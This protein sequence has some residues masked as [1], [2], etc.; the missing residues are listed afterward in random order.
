MSKISK[1][2]DGMHA[3]FS[4]D[5]GE[6]TGI[7]AGLFELHATLKATV[8]KGKRMHKTAEVYGDYLEQGREIAHLMWKFQYTMQVE[9]GIAA[10]R[11]HFIFEDFVLRRKREG[12][13]TG[14][15]TSCWVASAA[16]MAYVLPTAPIFD[17]L[18]K[19]PGRVPDLLPINWQQPSEGYF[20]RDR[21]KEYDLWVVGSEHERLCNAH[22]C[23]RVSKV[24]GT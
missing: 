21:L 23:C 8:T 5:P 20:Y 3:F 24:L 15:L 17:P 7:G 14:N 2:N 19:T 12:G 11:I 1:Q 4:V 18:D 10:D 22:I 6:T 13:A 9:Q 16:T